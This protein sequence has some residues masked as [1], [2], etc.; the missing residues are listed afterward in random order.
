MKSKIIELSWRLVIIISAIVGLFVL[1]NPYGIGMQ[2]WFF[3]VQTNI[4]VVIIESI[5]CVCLI[6]DMCGK[7]GHVRFTYEFWW[8]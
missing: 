3:T 5:L 1:H 8:Y 7:N 4:F 6:R 2:F